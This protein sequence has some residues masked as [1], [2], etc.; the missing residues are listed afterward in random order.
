MMTNFRCEYGIVI[1][2]MIMNNILNQIKDVVSA[3]EPT[4]KIMLFGSRARGDAKEDS[5]W[6]IIILLDKDRITSSDIDNISYPVREL[7]WQIDAMINPL[8][9]TQ[10]EWKKKSF[11]PFYKNVMKEGIAI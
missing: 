5:D 8:L 3:K 10:N 2:D 6:D 7:G 11:T 1:C 9:Y 4:A